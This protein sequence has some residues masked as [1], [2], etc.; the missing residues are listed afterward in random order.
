MKPMIVI[1]GPTASGKTTLSIALAQHYNAEIISADAMQFYRHLDIGTAK[2][3]PSEQN[4]IPHHLIDIIDPNA[5][6]S[7]ADYQRIVRAKI[8]ELRQRNITPILVGGSGLYIKSVLYNYRFNG[9][10]RDLKT[11]SMFAHFTNEELYAKLTVIAPLIAKKTHPNNRKQV[12]RLLELSSDNT[13]FDSSE[14]QQ[15]Y[16]PCFVMIGLQPSRP[17]LYER[18]N[19]RIDKM[20]EA[21]LIAEARHLYDSQI[22]GQSIMAIGYKEL[23]SYF[24]GDC[25]LAEAIDKIKQNSRNYAKRQM[26]WFKNQFIVEWFNPD[27][28]NFDKTIQEVISYIDTKSNK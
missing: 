2:I 14:G 4:G 16:D 21:G 20:I 8:D 5:E 19:T 1:V 11:T 13:S 25:L 24:K 9:K 7:V 23:Y 26:T 17:I 27:F 28:D 22:F 6:F 3:M 12:I 15:V 18:I 10:K